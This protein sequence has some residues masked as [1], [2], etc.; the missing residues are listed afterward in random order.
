MGY[1]VARAVNG[2]QIGTVGVVGSSGCTVI[3]QE[4]DLAQSP[5][6]QGQVLYLLVQTNVSLA[7]TGTSLVMD[8]GNGDLQRAT[9]SDSR[10]VGSWELHTFQLTM[11][12]TGMAR[13]GMQVF[14]THPA[15]ARTRVAVEIGAVV[16]APV[17]Q[18]WDRLKTDDDGTNCTGAFPYNP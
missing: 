12:L 18:P 9:E 1:A 8:G 16:L 4:I 2:V 7:Q 14:S 5:I 11:G 3:F 17:G 6:A 13:F 15:A 10:S